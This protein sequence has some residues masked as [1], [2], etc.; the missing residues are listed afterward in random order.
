MLAKADCSIWPDD[1]P[2]PSHITVLDLVYN[3]RNTRLLQQALDAGA[4]AI[5]GLDMLIFQGAVSFSLWTGKKPPIEAMR[6][7]L[8][9]ELN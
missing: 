9:E 2:I 5:S 4:K 1:L 3:P 8:E 7:A 6:K